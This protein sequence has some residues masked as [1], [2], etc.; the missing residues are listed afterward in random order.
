MYVGQTLSN[1]SDVKG[2]I[3][4]MALV[5]ALC[6]D[7]IIHHRIDSSQYMPFGYL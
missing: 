4:E 5:R 3:V 6:V 1:I 2:P 7:C